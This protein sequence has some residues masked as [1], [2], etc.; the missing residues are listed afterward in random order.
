[1]QGVDEGG[2]A[3]HDEAVAVGPS[4]GVGLVEAGGRG[5]DGARAGELLLH[6][7]ALDLLRA[8]QGAQALDGVRGAVVAS[9]LGAD[10][11]DPGL[12][13]AGAQEEDEDLQGPDGG[14]LPP[15]G[16][17]LIEGGGDIGEEGGRLDG[18]GAV[19][20]GRR[21]PLKARAQVARVGAGLLD[22]G[23]GER[24]QGAAR[25]ALGE[26]VARRRRG[27][28]GKT[29]HDLAQGLDVRA[30]RFLLSSLLPQSPGLPR[31]RRG[32]RR[33]RTP[34]LGRDRCR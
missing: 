21:A 5:D 13:A 32:A 25:A 34:A 28:V 3:P 23:A 1:M 33:R 24:G 6:G 15:G 11:V 31:P 29:G 22:G 30:H 14:L 17:V 26:P 27:G 2:G 19:V 7:H 8:G 18:L 10:P 4:P 9:R 16:H 20:G 12:G